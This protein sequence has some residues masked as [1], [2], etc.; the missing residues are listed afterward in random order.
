[1]EGFRRLDLAGGIAELATSAAGFPVLDLDLLEAVLI[2]YATA[3]LWAA[4][5]WFLE[6]NREAFH[7]CEPFLQKLESRRPRAPQYL[8]RS[9]RGGRFLSR[10]NLVLPP[11][12]NDRGEPDER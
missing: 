12:I 7:V 6:E 10:W 3:N 9:Q 4:T 5:G 1:V 8:V 11:E 2:R